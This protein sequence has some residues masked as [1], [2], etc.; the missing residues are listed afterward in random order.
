MIGFYQLPF[1]HAPLPLVAKKLAAQNLSHD[2]LTRA[3]LWLPTERARR[4]L[5][6]LLQLL[7][8]GAMPDI[9]LIQENLP[10]YQDGAAAT[11][12]TLQEPTPLMAQ[13]ATANWLVQ[14]D[15]RQGQSLPP[16]DV[17]HGRG[18][19]AALAIAKQLLQLHQQLIAHNIDW[20]QLLQADPSAWSEQAM[21]G[22]QLLQDWHEWWPG[23]LQQQG[24]TDA[25]AARQD[26]LARL[27]DSWQQSPPPLIWL[28]GAE[29]G[30]PLHQQFIRLLVRL[31]D[32]QTAM[33]A[34][35]GAHPAPP[36]SGQSQLAVLLPNLPDYSAAELVRLALSPRHPHGHW[37]ALLQNFKGAGGWPLPLWSDSP[38]APSSPT[39]QGAAQPSNP[40][41]S[42]RQH[43]LRQW[44]PVPTHARSTPHPYSRPEFFPQS[45]Q[46]FIENF[47]VQPCRDQHQEAQLI[48][49]AMRRALDNPNHKAALITPDRQLAKQVAAALKRWN[50]VVDDSAGQPLIQTPLGRLVALSLTAM[51]PQVE[52]SAVLSLLYHPLC[53][54]GIDPPQLRTIARHLDAA[55]R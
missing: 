18:W 46:A 28:L 6:Q 15:S 20:H 11:H 30:N 29:A 17:G 31:S 44:F 33:Q 5:I 8:L 35:A 24:Y 7:N 51:Q 25:K 4:T 45:N 9:R 14:R 49:L 48:A 39:P 22:Q 21:V 40:S 54:L 32:T 13:L 41:L 26:G 27:F 12:P 10:A 52:A 2:Q 42:G 19:H 16:D 34:G 37:I 3:Q 38:P 55:W 43:L 1:G 23:W 47:G 36:A 50:I 53:G